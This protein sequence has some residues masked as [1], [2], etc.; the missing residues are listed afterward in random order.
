MRIPTDQFQSLCLKDKDSENV[1][2][3]AD[4]TVIWR[5]EE[6]HTTSAH[7]SDGLC[8]LEEKD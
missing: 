4:D 8:K 7:P 1:P 3:Y 6:K 5:V 2:I